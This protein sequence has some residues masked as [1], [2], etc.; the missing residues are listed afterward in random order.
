MIA[1]LAAVEDVGTD[2]ANQAVVAI[3]PEQGIVAVV[4]VD[5]FVAGTEAVMTSSPS[6]PDTWF[7]ARAD[8]PTAQAAAVIMSFPL[9]PETELVAWALPPS[10]PAEARIE[11]SPSPPMIVFSPRA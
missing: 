9:S 7:S 1:A 5:P 6:P 4:A 8:P 3:A 10:A 11:S 2:A